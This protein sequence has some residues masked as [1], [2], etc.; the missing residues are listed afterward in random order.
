MN[1]MFLPQIENDVRQSHS[2]IRLE[3]LISMIRNAE[4]SRHTY[5]CFHAKLLPLSL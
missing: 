3:D 1:N 4:K 5:L 2:S